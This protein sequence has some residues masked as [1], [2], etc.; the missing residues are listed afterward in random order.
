MPNPTLHAATA[1]ETF[2]ND[3]RAP[4]YLTISAWAVPVLMIGQFALVS[5]IPV[6]LI[7]YAAFRDTRV[8]ALRWWAA[9]L[10]ALYVAPLA[11]WLTRDG[12]AESLSKDIHPAFVA[13]V[14]MAALVIAAKIH[15]SHRA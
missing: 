8:R 11:L 14:S 15:R 5:A 12:G 3:K 1:S 9:A 6:A 13:L 4:T 10:A 2:L 7:A